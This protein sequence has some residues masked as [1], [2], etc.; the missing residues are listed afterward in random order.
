MN[1]ETRIAGCSQYAWQDGELHCEGISLAQ[2]AEEYGTPLYVYSKAAMVER[3]RMLRQAFGPRAGIAYAIKSNSNLSLLR[4]FADLGAGFDL[5]SLG[6]LRRIQAAGIR[7]ADMVFAGVAKQEQELEAALEAGITFFNLESRREL[8][9]L[10]AAGVRSGRAVPIALRLNVDVDA[11]T[12]EYI[13]TGRRQDK[14]GLDLESASEALREIQAA[15]HLQLVGYHIHL[16]SQIRSARPFLEAFAKVEEFMAAAPEHREGLRYYDLGGGFG[17][18][19]GD[20]GGHL[21]V[22]ALAD[23]LLPRL[24]AHNLTPV[25]EPGRFL[26]G[27]AG[28][29]L[30]RVLGRK[31]GGDRDFLLVD[32]AMNDLLRPSHYGAEHPVAAVSRPDRPTRG[33]VDVV[34]PICE[35]GDFLALGRSLPDMQE[36]ELLSVFSAGAYGAAMTLTYNSRPRPAEVLVDGET[37]QLIRRRD[38]YPD[39]WAQELDL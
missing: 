1:Q 13:S 38:S 9:L 23:E 31:P 18:S 28:V 4:L 8:E 15:E 20:G 34:G 16:G 21:D 24:E 12:H 26:V 27:D 17:I 10:E 29:L 37:S 6:E 35:S 30:C 3:Y 22:Q 25:L 11:E 32:G 33:K 36:G 39:L 2:L 7:D 5:V 14:F 19:Y